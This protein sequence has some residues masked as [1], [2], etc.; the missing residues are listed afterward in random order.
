MGDAACTANQLFPVTVMAAIVLFFMRE[1]FDL[2]K[3]KS[4]RSRKISAYRILIAEELSKNAWAVMKMNE[5]FVEIA[6]ADFQRLTYEKS[7]A[8]SE[9]LS[10]WTS[11][12]A[13]SVRLWA[14]HTTI[15]DKAV[16]ELAAL[17]EKLFLRAKTAYESL[18]EVKHLRES[19]INWAED[20]CIKSFIKGLSGHG[21]SQ[22]EEADK[23]IKKLYLTCTGIELSSHKL[24][25]YV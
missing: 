9:K 21:L 18:A 2:Y 1:I 14:V 12:G 5:I 13:Y 7:A 15:F 10:I 24:R 17:D 4:A 11:D 25:S 6:D 16:I 19:L 22:L 8:G 23:A 3:I 20:D